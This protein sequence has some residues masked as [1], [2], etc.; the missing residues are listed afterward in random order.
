MENLKQNMNTLELKQTN[1]EK[2]INNFIDEHKFEYNGDPYIRTDYEQEEKEMKNGKTKLHVLY[3]DGTIVAYLCMR[4]ESPETVCFGN[5][6][7]GKNF[8][9]KGYG[10]LLLQHGVEL[11]KK[12]GYKEIVL[13]SRRGVEEFYYKCGFNGNGL[14]QADIDKA[15]KKD[16][17]DLLHR[18]NIFNYEYKVWNNQGHQFFVNLKYIKDMESFLNDVDS[19]HY[20]F[21]TTFDKKIENEKV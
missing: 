11:A 19:Y 14:L 7:V 12:F 9:G 21:I 17:E 10:K 16:M 8:R 18:H 13:G 1:D 15:D 2:I 4:E 20:Y 3:V 6:L 5:V